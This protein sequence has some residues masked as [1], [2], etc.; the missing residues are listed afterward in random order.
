MERPL[1]SLPAEIPTRLWKE[2]VVRVLEH[3]Q[4]HFPIE[5]SESASL[6]LLCD[7]L[8]LHTVSRFPGSCHFLE[9]VGQPCP[10][11]SAEAPDNVAFL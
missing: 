10:S 6:V 1:G 7:P 9:T 2:C 4:C 3:A 8:L 11:V 5:L